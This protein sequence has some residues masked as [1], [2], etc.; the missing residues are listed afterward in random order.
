MIVD[1]IN[2]TSTSLCETTI[3]RLKKDK[4]IKFNLQNK[5]QKYQNTKRLKG[6]VK[7]TISNENTTK[8]I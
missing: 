1:I 2:P 5:K 6:L 4:Y 3:S 8:T 7:R